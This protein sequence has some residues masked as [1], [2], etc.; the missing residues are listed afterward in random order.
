MLRTI[1]EEPHVKEGKNEIG[2][3]EAR[4]PKPL[5]F[6]H[7]QSVEEAEELSEVDDS[8]LNTNRTALGDDEHA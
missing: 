3:R 6:K 2:A 7:Q 5:I 1:T 4:G 8:V